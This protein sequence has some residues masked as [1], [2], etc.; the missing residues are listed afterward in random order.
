LVTPI[1]NAAYT[2]ALKALLDVLPEQVFA[3]KVVLPVCIAGSPAHLLA[4]DYALRPVLASMGA[5][6]VLRGV[7]LVQDGLPRNGAGVV[8][9]TRDSAQRVES[10]IDDL[11]R[12]LDQMSS[13]ASR[14]G[15]KV[16]RKS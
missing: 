16:M 12:A 11:A 13:D 1:Y 14:L 3:D 7:L 2:G 4:I 15:S 9:L 8:E 5:P 6:R 10:A